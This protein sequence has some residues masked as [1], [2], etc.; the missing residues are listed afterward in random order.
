MGLEKRI[1]NGVHDVAVFQRRVRVLSEHLAGE[2]D[3][4]GTALDVGCG[5]GSIAQAIMTLRPGLSFEGIDVML[6]PRSAIPAKAYDGKRIPHEDKSFDWVTVVD[7][8]H[9]TDDPARVLVECL[10]V[11][12]RGVVLK[13]HL[14]DGLGAY[15]TLRLMDW[16]GNRGHD[17]R[18]P[19]NYL[20]RAE[21]NVLFR[22]IGASPASWKESLNLYPPPFSLVFDRG[23]HFVATL[24]PVVH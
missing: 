16:V 6:R 8:L 4:G 5:D 18:L 24:V 20:S 23:L 7:V 13:D 22:E 3:G 14:R 11:A 2:I 15:P 21:W 1:L 19:Y 9:H 10:R 12:R 17:V